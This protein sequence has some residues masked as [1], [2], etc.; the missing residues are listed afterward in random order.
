MPFFRCVREN[1]RRSWHASLGVGIVYTSPGSIEAQ[2]MVTALERAITEL[3]T[4]ERCKTMRTAVGKCRHLSLV[5]P[6]ENDRLVEQSAC[7]ELPGVDLI[8]KASDVPRVSQV[9]TT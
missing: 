5:G 8:G 7:Q 3:A 9:H 6:E 4:R 2:A 1:A